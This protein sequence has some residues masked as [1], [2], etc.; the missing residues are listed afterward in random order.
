M[1]LA[2]ICIGL[3]IGGIVG[4]FVGGLMAAAKRGDDLLDRRDPEWIEPK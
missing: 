4:M 2:L 3:G 1:S